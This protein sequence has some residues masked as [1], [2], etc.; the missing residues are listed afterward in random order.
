LRS[1]AVHAVTRR[2]R[3]AHPAHAGGSPEEFI[4]AAM[5]EFLAL[6]AAQL[7]VILAETVV[8]YVTRGAVRAAGA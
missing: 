1:A 8:R 6:L 4:V 5:E 7:L 2:S 3:I